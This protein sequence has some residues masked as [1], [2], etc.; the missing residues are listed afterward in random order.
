MP[1][2]DQQLRQ[3]LIKLGET[4]PPITQR[5]REDL[6]ARLEVLQA[7][8]HA[9]VRTSPT[10]T[11]VN[12][13]PS[14]TA[15]RSRPVRGLIELSDSETDTSAND[16]LPT[17]PTARATRTQTRS[18]AVGRDTQVSPT[19]TADV[20]ESSEIS[21]RYRSENN[22]LFF[23]VARHRREIQ[24]LIDSARDR[25]RAVHGNPSTSKYEP[26]SITPL[27][28]TSGSSQPR[29]PSKSSY[30]TAKG[31][32]WFNRT[33]ESIRSFWKTYNDVILNALKMI[34]V[35]LILGGALILLKK[36]AKNIIPHRQGKSFDSQDRCL[37]L[38]EFCYRNYVYS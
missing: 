11:R 6:R 37:T 35:G 25:T 22:G 27:R 2:T 15:T 20:E 38:S 33:G 24:Q 13:S 26:T 36:N 30:T 19:A 1:L 12:T 4:V 34:L 29:P 23:I 31:P 10:R 8:S 21:C 14:R 5:N 18:I 3:E 32:S 9:P 17:R 28:P 7:R 16:Y